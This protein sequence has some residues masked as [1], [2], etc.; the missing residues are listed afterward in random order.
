MAHEDFKVSNMVQSNLARSISD[1]GQYTSQR[2]NVCEHIWQEN[3]DN[4]VFRCVSCGHEDHVDCDAA[5]NSLD[6]GTSTE[7]GVLLTKALPSG[8]DRSGGSRAVA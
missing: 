1:V 7:G 6:R 2:C 4:E 3:R 8:E 5:K